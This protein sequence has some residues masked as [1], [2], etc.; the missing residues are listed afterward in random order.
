ML[1]FNYK[2]CQCDAVYEIDPELMLC[3]DCSATQRSGQP[4]N[5][6]LE[7]E[8]KGSISS[9]D[10]L[11]FLPVEREFFPAI[12]VGNTPLWHPQNLVEKYAFPHLY[13]KDDGVNPTGS[14]KDRASFLVAAF[15][16]KHGIR[17]VV[18]ASTGNAGSSMAGVGAAAGL[19]IKL[20][21]P[22]TAPPAK[23]IQALQYGAD[24]VLAEKNY[25]QAFALSLEYSRTRGG[26]NRNTAYNPMTVE[27]K[28][29]VSLEIFNQLAPE[30]PDGKAPDH[31]F[32][33]VGD[34]VILSGI[35]KGF[36]DLLQLGRIV[37]IPTVHAV[38]A[39][40]SAAIYRA[41]ETGVFDGH[42]AKTVA[43]SISVDVPSNGHLAVKNLKAYD[44]KCITVSDDEILSAQKELSSA[45][46]LFSEPAAATAY[47]GF[48]K[49]KSSLDSGE[50]C[51][52]L[53]TGNGLKDTNSAANNIIL[54]EKAI[55]S[56]DEI[57]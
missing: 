11:D 47:A 16:R 49:Q 14:L 10:P 19:K 46:G 21:L 31:V 34:G 54:P 22:K 40:G 52:V 25:D 5:G 23:M 8:L 45:C 43:D 41:L 3:P 9:H 51:V 44:G 38:Q 36:R 1:S 20:F 18:V 29:T 37:K 55:N 33:G 56:L 35:Y 26:M 24:V 28:K 13:L 42:P 4:L 57:S 6:V 17:E 12:P 53:L 39:S 30:V 2:C 7:V 50:T 32:V 48:L 27:G 15:A